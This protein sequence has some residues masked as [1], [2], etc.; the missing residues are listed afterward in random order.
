MQ[1]KIVKQY[2]CISLG[3]C[4]LTALLC[5]GIVMSVIMAVFLS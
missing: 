4:L 3:L 2:V 5:Y 1:E